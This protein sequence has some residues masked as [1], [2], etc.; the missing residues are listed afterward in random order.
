MTSFVAAN[1]RATDP[2]LLPAQEV[3]IDEGVIW[4]TSPYLWMEGLPAL[5]M[6]R[7]GSYTGLVERRWGYDLRGYLQPG[8]VMP[9]R[10]AVEDRD[11]LNF[12]VACGALR[13]ADPASGLDPDVMH[14]TA[15]SFAWLSRIDPGGGGAIFGNRI[16][17]EQFAILI[18]PISGNINVFSRFPAKNDSTTA[19]AWDDGEWHV[20]VV[21]MDTRDGVSGTTVHRVDGVVANAGFT[22]GARPISTL[23]G[24]QKLLIG[25]TSADASAYSL[26]DVQI[27]AAIAFAGVALHHSPTLLGSVERYLTVIKNG[28]IA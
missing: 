10:V 11:V 1:A 24:A 9:A 3:S 23:S 18:D 4:A 13:L 5:F 16:F 17:A 22:V 20:H 26:T 7:E 25:A 14:P 2:L 6:P 28:L 19:D 27:G 12:T 15:N 21:S 8:K